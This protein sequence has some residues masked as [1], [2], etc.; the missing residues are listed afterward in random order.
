MA[1]RLLRAVFSA[2]L[3]GAPHDPP[4]EAWGARAVGI[5]RTRGGLLAALLFPVEGAR[6]LVVLGHPGIPPAKGYF[7]RNDRIPFLHERGFAVLTFDHGGFGESDA[8]NALYDAEWTDALAWA[9]R[10]FPDLPLSAWGLSMSGYFLH[11]ALAQDAGVEACVFEEVSPD[12]F[13]Y[14]HAWQ[15]RAARVALRLVAPRAARWFPAEAHAADVHA[16][17]V[18]YVWAA[19]DAGIPA[20]HQERLFA[21]AGPLARRHVAAGAGHLEAWKKG[22]AAVRDEVA[23]L[24]G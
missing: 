9:R 8:P 5:P 19:Q 16:H 4:P 13:A 20:P 21:A 23:R 12:L 10:R 17:R 14:G 15:G 3:E 2:S 7:H 11:H 6:G 18:L 24:L 1:G 22:G